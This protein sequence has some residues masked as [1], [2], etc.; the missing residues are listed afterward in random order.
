M[1]SIRKIA[2]GAGHL[3]IP[4]IRSKSRRESSVSMMKSAKERKSNNVA[5]IPAFGLTFFWCIFAQSQVS[6]MVM[7]VE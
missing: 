3:S 7:I 5:F 4:K 2:R 1:L 6:T